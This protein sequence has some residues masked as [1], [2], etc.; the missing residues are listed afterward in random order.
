MLRRLQRQRLRRCRR[1]LCHRDGFPAAPLRRS[2]QGRIRTV[3][4]TDESRDRVP[5]PGGRAGAGDP[6]AM[7]ARERFAPAKASG[8]P[9]PRARR[10]ICILAA[11]TRGIAG[12]SSASAMVFKVIAPDGGRPA[13][14][15]SGEILPGDTAR[16]LPW[17][18]RL[19]EGNI[20]PR[21]FLSSPAGNVLEATRLANLIHE[22]GSRCSS[23]R[24]IC[25]PPPTS[26]SSPHR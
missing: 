7:A 19:S 12:P 1:G 13:L 4:W 20:A 24:E 21:L 18:I 6:H 22:T 9:R 25:V 26:F 11:V 17:L 15:M 10:V 2:P 16:I 8:C 5:P 14:S 3:C 23:K